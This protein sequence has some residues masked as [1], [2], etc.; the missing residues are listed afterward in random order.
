VIVGGY[1]SDCGRDKELSPLMT[2]RLLAVA[3]PYEGVTFPLP[4]G[5]FTIGRDT[6]NALSLAADDRVSRRHAVIL[7][8]DQQFTIRDLTARERTYVNRLP[9]PERVLEH[10]DEIRVGGSV[11]VF[12]AD[13]QPDPPTAAEVELD[14][15]TH[16]DGSRRTA[17]KGDALYLDRESLLEGVP[18]N[19]QGARLVKS[20][21][22][23]C[24]AILFTH[25]LPD[26]ERQLLDSITGAI[27]A[28]RAAVLL[29][30]DRAEEFA[31][32]RYWARGAGECRSFRIPR[33]VIQH[34]LTEGAALCINDASYTVFSS[35][36]V[37]QA[38]L[39]SMMAVPLVESNV[40]RGAIYL[41][42]SNPAVRFGEGDLQLLTGIAEVSAG[43]LVNA[44]KMEKLEREN[45]RLLSQL[46]E[47][48]ALIGASE[49]MRAVH[50]FVAKVAASNSTVLITG[51]TG[52]GKEIVARA[53]HHTSARA[54]RPFAAINCAAV[55]ETLLESEFFGHEKGAFTGAYAAKKGKLEEADGGTVFLDE[56]G[57]LAPALQ[58]K[59]LRVLQERE[60]ERVGGTRP[61]K[62]DVRILAATN[63][64]LKEEIRRGGFREDLFYRLNVVAVAM[65]DLRE[66]REDIPLLAAHFLRTRARTCTRRISQISPEALACLMAYDW[67]GNV[68]ELENVIERAIVLGTTEQILPDDLPE[69][70]AESG[71]QSPG[72][73]AKFHEM[74]REIKKQLVNRAL[75]DAGGSY[76]EAARLLGLHP[77]NL[78]RLMKTLGMKT[79]D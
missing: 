55:T 70:I 41:D 63:R 75:K 68:R 37:V 6:G 23:A 56:I 12:L 20:V 3:G 21:L 66:R 9:V 73:R 62:V 50:R 57:E 59:L 53:I 25:G 27:P 60:F 67:P 29:V 40:P 69:S 7:G 4:L 78:H 51:A 1:Q 47:K 34:V 46:S 19:D 49:R 74:I 10:G 65:P 26:L 45:D 48:H 30:A 79:K 77:N 54:A 24:R 52:T 35:K 61:I 15:S 5:E 8:L 11:F 28:E 32:A 72:S 18:Q 2:A 31:S 22:T 44:L 16:V 17:R 14:E 42:L 71:V 43:P 36:T 33:A 76:A 38:R 64:D 13:G 39:T 58:A